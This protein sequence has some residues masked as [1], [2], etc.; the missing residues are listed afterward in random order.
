MDDDPDDWLLIEQ[1]LKRQGADRPVRF[2]AD[3]QVLLDYL[4][5]QGAFAD[6]AAHPLPAFILLDLN[7]PRKD[8]RQALKEIKEH[9]T[10]RRIP[11][12]ILSTS[13][14]EID[15]TICYQ[16]GCSGFFTKPASFE[17]FTV[18]METIQRYWIDAVRLPRPALLR[19]C[20]GV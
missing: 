18:L 13:Q 10:L 6:R 7:M 20:A 1:A 8:G 17:G 11:V 2:L 16:L 19:S 12:L 3:G 9:P 15:T 5:S 4:N 14:N